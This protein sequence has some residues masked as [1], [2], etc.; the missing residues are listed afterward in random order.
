MASPSLV[1]FRIVGANGA[2]KSMVIPVASAST[3]AE[4]E[5]F[6]AEIDQLLDNC[7]DGYI[8]LV[9]VTK[10]VSFSVTGDTAAADRHVDDGGLLSFSATGIDLKYG[11]YV[12]TF[13]LSLITDTSK[14]IANAGATATFLAA[15]LGGANV[16]VTDRNDHVLSGF[17][18]GTRVSRK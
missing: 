6:V 4:I 8:D 3:Q 16:D 11:I 2:K 17:L 1:S 10:S 15:L 5:A 14:D 12:P 13:A 9:T 18:K 7:I